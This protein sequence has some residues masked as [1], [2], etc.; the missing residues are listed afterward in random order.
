MQLHGCYLELVAHR[1]LE[2]WTGLLHNFKEGLVQLPG[3]TCVTTSRPAITR[4]IVL[5]QAT[6]SVF[7]FSQSCSALNKEIPDEESGSDY[8][9]KLT[10]M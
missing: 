4:E 5:K 2:V 3:C 1:E 10:T 6:L 7:S 8:K 9:R